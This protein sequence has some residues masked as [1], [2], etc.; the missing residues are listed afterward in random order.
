M[1]GAATTAPPV[2]MDKQV[3]ALFGHVLTPMAGEKVL[4][5]KQ[6]GTPQE[7]E[8]DSARK[9]PRQT[10]QSPPKGK[11]K[12]RG[13]P[14]DKEEATYSDSSERDLVLALGRIVLQQADQL[15]RLEL[16]TGFFL[17]LATAPAAGTVIPTMFEVAELWR[18]KQMET[19]EQIT[20]SLGV[21]M[22]RCLLQELS[23]RLSHALKTPEVVAALTKQEM[24]TDKQDWMYMLW[25]KDNGKLM[26]DPTR[27]PL[28][29]KDLQQTIQDAANMLQHHPEVITRFC[30]TQRL[31][32]STQHA[33]VPFLID[34][35]LRDGRMFQIL[36]HG[37]QTASPLQ[38]LIRRLVQTRRAQL[39]TLGGWGGWGGGKSHNS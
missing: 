16:D 30:S 18:K 6:G 34:V 7:M 24:L 10:R 20:C 8:V 39:I 29:T 14:K 36:Q 13:K 21:M 26:P 19:P 27:N 15:H 4:G 28:S 5:S 38:A 9:R 25:D 12:G 37:G 31:D 11:G 2:A 23:N 17:V 32:A 22:M 33:Q 35:S 3:M 1:T